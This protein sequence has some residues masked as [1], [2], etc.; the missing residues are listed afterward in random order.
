MKTRNKLRN[1]IRRARQSITNEEQQQFA[2]QL[3]DTL[4]QH[5]LVSKAKNIAI[6][7]SN[8]GEID[9]TPFIKWCWLNNKAVYLPVVHPFTKGHLLFLNYLPQS[10]VISNQYGILEPELNV[11]NIIS[12][13]QLDIIFTPLVAFDNKGNRLGMGGGY[14][15][16]L[17]AP[18]FENKMGGTPIGL[19]HD[20][21][22]V[23]HIP[24]E[25]WDVPLPEII[26]PSKHFLITDIA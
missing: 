11:Q 8:D 3:A 7:I 20:C 10:Q 6:F 21:Q 14:Y 18:W 22:Q 26:T 12:P 13:R 19:A 4:A 24:I 23:K 5:T 9:T 25:A 16:R 15:D 2:L 17:L 1:E